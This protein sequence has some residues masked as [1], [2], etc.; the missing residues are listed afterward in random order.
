MTTPVTAR[1]TV[2]RAATADLGELGATLAKIHHDYDPARF[3]YGEDFA[4][5]YA[6]WFVEE[7][8]RARRPTVARRR[9]FRA[10][11]SARRCWR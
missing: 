10:W 6:W 7:L 11:A 4:R 3:R 5:G 1:A 8:N 9:C 2:R